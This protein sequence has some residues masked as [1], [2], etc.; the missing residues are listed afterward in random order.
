MRASGSDPTSPD[1][2]APKADLPVGLDQLAP[3]E[4]LVLWWF[5]CWILGGHPDGRMRLRAARQ[6]IEDHLGADADRFL[7]LLARVVVVLRG[8]A[9]TSF[10]VH[11]PCCPCLGPHE[12][13]VLTLISAHQYEQG[14]LVGA[15]GRWLVH[16]DGRPA[17]AEA[18]GAVSELLFWHGLMLPCRLPDHRRD[19]GCA[20]PTH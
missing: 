13:A 12:A 9:R 18:M 2:D 16:E 15:F 17:L 11:A 19:P 10:P 3:A 7:S 1:G 6:S 8:H 5:R 14:G 20:G 4:R